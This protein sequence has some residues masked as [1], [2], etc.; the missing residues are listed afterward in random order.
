MD[1]GACETV[2]CGRPRALIAPV[3]RLG[4][5]RALIVSQRDDV[6]DAYAA[7]LDRRA[8]VYGVTS[9]RELIEVLENIAAAKTPLAG[10]DMVVLDVRGPGLS[11][12]DALSALG[13]ARWETPWLVLNG[14]SPP[15]D[16]LAYGPTLVLIAKEDASAS[17]RP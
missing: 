3:L 7:R 8:E 1:G 14:D 10:M 5:A 17:E 6:C 11:I 4:C 15:F 16:V 2:I 9:R 13:A 12:A